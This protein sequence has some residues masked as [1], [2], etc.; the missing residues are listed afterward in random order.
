LAED[1]EEDMIVR[2]LRQCSGQ[3]VVTAFKSAATFDE[4]VESKWQPHEFVDKFQYKPGSVR[5]T[6]R[7][8]GVWVR[9]S[10]LRK[11]WVLFGKKVWK[12]DSSL[13]FTLEPVALTNNYDEVEVAVRYVYDI[14]QGGY[15][16]VA[17]SPHSPQFE[18]IRPQFERFLA[19]FFAGLQPQH[20]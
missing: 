3:E 19:N 18:H 16:Y 15:E 7:S 13:T 4:A 10:F 5:Q 9:P 14:D 12:L 2:L 8:M 17:T 20:A 11:K 1:K 6:I